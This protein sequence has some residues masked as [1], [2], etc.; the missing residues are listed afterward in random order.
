M[1]RKKLVNTKEASEYTGVAKRTLENWRQRGKG[2]VY[3]D[4]DGMIRYDLDDL[5]A[6]LERRKVHPEYDRAS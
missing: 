3:V 4:M 1:Q 5:D 6:F 2:P